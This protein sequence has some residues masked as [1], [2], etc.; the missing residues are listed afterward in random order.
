MKAEHCP[1]ATDDLNAAA[2]SPQCVHVGKAVARCACAA[3]GRELE[4]DSPRVGLAFRS[5]RPLLQVDKF[6]IGSDKVGTVPLSNDVY[7]QNCASV[8][9]GLVAWR[10]CEARCAG[11]LTDVFVCSHSAV[12][13]SQAR[14]ATAREVN[15]KGAGDVTNR[16]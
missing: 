14:M 4:F 2:V 6:T 12:I 8:L 3:Q 7:R 9:Q 16:A 15:S 5:K 1:F 13:D 11:T 10:A